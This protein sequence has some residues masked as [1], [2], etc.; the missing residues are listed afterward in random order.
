MFPSSLPR[1]LGY[2]RS[3]LLLGRDLDSPK[4]S[5]QS[6]LDSEYPSDPLS[7]CFEDC[8]LSAILELMLYLLCPNIGCPITLFDSL[9]QLVIT[10]GMDSSGPKFDPQYCWWV[11]IMSLVLSVAI[12]YYI[13]IDA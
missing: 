7:L 9:G 4:Y 12:G 3:L 10:P 13:I 6:L 1:L 11:L 5:S 2:N 8:W